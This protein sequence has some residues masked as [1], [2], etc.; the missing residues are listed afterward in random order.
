[1]DWGFCWC[2]QYSDVNEKH[3]RTHIDENAT[4]KNNDSFGLLLFFS[5]SL[6]FM[7]IDCKR[8]IPLS[9]CTVQCERYGVK[10]KL[11]WPGLNIR[12]VSFLFILPSFNKVFVRICVPFVSFKLSTYVQFSKSEKKNAAKRYNLLNKQILQIIQKKER[13][14][15]CW[16]TMI[17]LR[18]FISCRC[19][20]SM[21]TEHSKI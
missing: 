6:V 18:N 5:L 3:I 1:M 9:L 12:N 17:F 8:R 20:Q 11:C 14:A 21:L 2:R 16:C 19:K 7:F 4:R 10:I 13:I 15:V